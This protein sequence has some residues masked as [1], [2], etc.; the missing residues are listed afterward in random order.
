M[1]NRQS[2]KLTKLINNEKRIFGQN[3]RK[4]SRL[5]DKMTG[6]QR[7]CKF[8]V[9]GYFDENK[10][11]SL[12]AATKIVCTNYLW[13]SQQQSYKNRP[14]TAEPKGQIYSSSRGVFPSDLHSYSKR[15]FI[16][17]FAPPFSPW[18]SP[19]FLAGL[20]REQG[21]RGELGESCQGVE[22]RVA[23]NFLIIVL[24]KH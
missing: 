18:L 11:F 13:H 16:G 10:C 8:I 7:K 15:R 9:E 4:T 21:G 17:P 3:D 23:R 24:Y 14:L 2:E 22:G 5:L 20:R 6:H 12:L 19:S 1:T